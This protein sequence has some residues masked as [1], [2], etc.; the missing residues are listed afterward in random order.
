MYKVFKRYN[1]IETII[2]ADI[3]GHQHEVKKNTKDYTED[4]M[5]EEFSELIGVMTAEEVKQ[6][7]IA[8]N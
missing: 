8:N 5:I 6:S 4:K 3:D 1:A 7:I 2:Y